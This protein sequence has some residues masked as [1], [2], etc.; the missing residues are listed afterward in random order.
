MAATARKSAI[1]RVKVAQDDLEAANRQLA[2][3]TEQRNAALLKDE[4]TTAIK[5]GIEI[6]NLKLE[7]RAHEDKIQLL[8][9]EAAREEKARREAERTALVG[10]I[11]AKIDQR[12]KAMQEVA[13]AIKQLAAASERAIE[14]NREII[15]S[16]T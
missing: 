16:W 10:K 6:A 11:E 2:E 15:S 7:A 13:A 12:D 5:L 4:T 8:R 14:L 3:L 1:D 9:E